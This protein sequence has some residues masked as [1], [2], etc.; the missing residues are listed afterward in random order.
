MTVLITGA[1][2][3][4]GRELVSL[5][6]KNG[7]T[8]H[9]LTTDYD[10]IKTEPDYIGF[11]W[12]PQEGK[13]DENCFVGVD[14][15]IHL[16]G[17]TIAKRWTKSYR[18]EIIESRVLSAN[19]LFK[20]LKDNPHQVKQLIAAS[21]IGIYSDSLIETYSES[22]PAIATDFLGNVVTSWEESTDKFGL[23]GIKVS[24]LRIGLVLSEKGGAL[25]QMVKPVKSGFGAAFG[26][27]KQW[28][29]WIHIEDLAAMF[30]TA[31]KQGWE[32]IFNAVAP[33][34]VTNTELTKSI[35]KVLRK[36]LWL[37][38]IP[39]FVMK[40]VLGEMHTLL[41]SSQKVSSQKAE[42]TGFVFKY[43]KIDKTLQ[44]IL[45]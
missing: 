41:F 38:N 30:Y 26:S 11:Y 40:L 44:S 31:A 3:L 14:T 24:K 17:A 7:V 5:F 10:K 4:V 43:T 16:A 19:L 23:L 12:N 34:P 29:S 15:V 21:A 42:S 13:I 36:P 27:G 45:K 9:Y 18:Q 28:Q 20:V 25:P 22:S 39:K 2:G 32:G 8:V 1:T 35:A 33:N 6:R 37:P